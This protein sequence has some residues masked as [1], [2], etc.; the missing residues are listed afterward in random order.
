MNCWWRQKDP[1]GA[2]KAADLGRAQ[3]CSFL[4][5]DLGF[6]DSMGNSGG[7]VSH[8]HQAHPSQAEML[9]GDMRDGSPDVT[10][11]PAVGPRGT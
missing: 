5:T 8:I 2:A 9:L 6:S 4:L 7:D 3:Q 11:G 10:P 1:L